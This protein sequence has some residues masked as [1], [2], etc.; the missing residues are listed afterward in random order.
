[1]RKERAAEKNELLMKKFLMLL[2]LIA[3]GIT[4]AE[5]QQRY[6]IPKFKKEKKVKEYTL[7]K[8]DRPVEVYLG[9]T[10]NFAL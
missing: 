5:A 7:V 2:V 1:M 8:E 3:L 6:Y 4:S 9:G 10:V